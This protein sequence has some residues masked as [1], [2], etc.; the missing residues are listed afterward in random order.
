MTVR[1]GARGKNCMSAERRI[2]IIA[3]PNGAGKSTFAREFLPNEAR[4][5][6][7]LNADLIAAG[8][9]PFDPSR[10]AV[11]AGR[12]MLAEMERY[13]V[14]G[15]SFG[16]E[17]TL[18]GLLYARRIPRWQAGGY[19]VKLIFLSLPTVDM[20]IARV[21]L[22]VRQG[23]HDIPEETIRRRYGAGWEA[24]QKT[25]KSLVDAWVLYDNSRERPLLIE[26][27]VKA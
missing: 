24:F 16:F 13:V 15:A 5:P 9:S 27:G 26:Q 2:L 18:S 10:A 7:F 1:L 11:R 14:A 22:R 8:L 25:Y 4:C 3:G 17:T 19:H 20:A 23:G 6:V 12:L 21:A